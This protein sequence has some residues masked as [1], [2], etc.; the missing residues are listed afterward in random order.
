MTL[1]DLAAMIG[2]IGFRFHIEANLI[3]P[4]HSLWEKLVNGGPPMARL[5]LPS[6]VGLVFIGQWALIPHVKASAPGRS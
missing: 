1:V 6:R 3:E 4:G 2:I 5:L